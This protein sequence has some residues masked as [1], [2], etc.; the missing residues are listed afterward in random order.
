MSTRYEEGRQNGY[1]SPQNGEEQY[2]NLN[3]NQGHYIEKINEVNNKEQSTKNNKNLES[4]V[5]KDQQKW[6]SQLEN[7]QKKGSSQMITVTDEKTNIHKHSSL[8]R[9]ENDSNINSST[10]SLHIVA[11]ENSPDNPNINDNGK[12]EKE[13]IAKIQKVNV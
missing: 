7:Q 11:Y 8:K 12:N 2:N 3:L 1:G 10:L 4:D 9:D 6:D 13:K 5:Q